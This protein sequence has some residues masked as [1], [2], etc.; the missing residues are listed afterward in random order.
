MSLMYHQARGECSQDKHPIDFHCF[1]WWKM[2]PSKLILI[3]FSLFLWKMVKCKV[4]P[5]L[6]EFRVH[7]FLIRKVRDWMYHGPFN[8][9]IM[10]LRS[11]LLVLL[12]NSSFV[13]EHKNPT[14]LSTGNH[15]KKDRTV[16]Y[17]ILVYMDH[18]HRENKVCHTVYFTLITAR[19]LKCFLFVL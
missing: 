12:Y 17:Q 18:H 14:K 11:W 1:T 15:D 2:L 6:L 13:C 9:L 10:R 19:I 3:V 5:R 8:K 4:A 7:L 16:K